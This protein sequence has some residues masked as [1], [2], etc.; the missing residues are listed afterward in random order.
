MFKTG[1]VFAATMLAIAVMPLAAADDG[2]RPLFDGKTFA[3]WKLLDG[4]RGH[5]VVRE[6]R[7]VAEDANAHRLAA[8]QLVRRNG[9]VIR[10][11][12]HDA[13]DMSTHGR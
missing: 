10:N 1:S 5:W 13:K 2:F 12:P 4:H 9:E 11:Q 6:R 8:A 7:H 3:G